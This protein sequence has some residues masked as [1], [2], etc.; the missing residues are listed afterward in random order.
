MPRQWLT[1]FH[2][3]LVTHQWMENHS[4]AI[5]PVEAPI[6]GDERVLLGRLMGAE[7]TTLFVRWQTGTDSVLRLPSETALGV[8][9]TRLAG[10]E[11][12]L[13][14]WV[15]QVTTVVAY[16]Q[17]CNRPHPPPAA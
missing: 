3:D 1:L 15:K 10:R 4:V 12:R 17:P 13:T 5:G 14:Y 8:L 7:G 9:L 2:R 6:L 16:K 11:G